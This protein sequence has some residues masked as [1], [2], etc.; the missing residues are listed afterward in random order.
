MTTIQQG[1]ERM[2]VHR[3]GEGAYVYSDVKFLRNPVRQQTFYKNIGE[4]G[5]QWGP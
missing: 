5:K 3:D 4:G 2:C 1:V